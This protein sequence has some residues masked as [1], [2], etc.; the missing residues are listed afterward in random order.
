MDSF[1]PVCQLWSATL[2]CIRDS[3]PKR[4]VQQH[5]SLKATQHATNRDKHINEESEQVFADN[6]FKISCKYTQDML[7]NWK[8]CFNVFNIQTYDD[9]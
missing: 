6:L 1:G 9:L 5:I 2:K 4:F 7:S 3:K 8:I